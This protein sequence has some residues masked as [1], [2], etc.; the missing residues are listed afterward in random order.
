MFRL[1]NWL[2]RLS[3]FGRG[4]SKW[5]IFSSYFICQSFTDVKGIPVF[6]SSNLFF[7][8]S[9]KPEMT[10]VEIDSELPWGRLEYLPGFMAQ[11]EIFRL[12]PLWSCTFFFLYYETKSSLTVSTYRLPLTRDSTRENIFCFTSMKTHFELK[13]ESGSKTLLTTESILKSRTG[14]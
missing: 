2:L 1:Y 13:R 5:R 3:Y 12:C 10:D 9:W 7:I 4:F 14:R 11:S 8:N 6:H